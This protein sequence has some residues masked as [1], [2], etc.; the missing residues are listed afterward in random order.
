MNDPGS[1]LGFTHR[2]QRTIRNGLW[3]QSQ[4][5]SLNTTKHYPK[6]KIRI[7][8]TLRTITWENKVV[9]CRCSVYA[10]NIFKSYIK[11]II[12]FVFWISTENQIFN[13]DLVIFLYSFFNWITMKLF[14]IK[15]L[16]TTMLQCYYDW[17]LG[18]QYFN[19]ST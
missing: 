5:K 1:I 15:L 4:K 19:V 7:T 14:F 9:N 8:K 17:V 18:L 6:N 2:S 11:P 16:W 12:K 13:E 10:I 3:A